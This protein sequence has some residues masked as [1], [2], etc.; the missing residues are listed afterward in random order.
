MSKQL[1][2]NNANA[3]PG[4]AAGVTSPAD[5]PDGRIAAFDPDNFAGG[6]LDLTLNQPDLEKIVFVQGGDSPIISP[7]F[8][9]E[10]IKPT[11]I[12]EQEYVAPVAQVTTVTPEAGTGFAYVRVVQVSEGYRPHER[13]T[14]EVKLDNKT[15][16]EIATELANKINNARP[17]FVS[18]AENAGTLVITGELETSFET[19]TD[20]EAEGWAI[21]ATTTPNFGTGTSAHVKAIEELAYGGNYTNRIYLPVTPDSYVVDGE[22]YDLFTIRVPTNTTPNI[23]SANKYL[24]IILAVQATATGINLPAV[25]NHEDDGA[26]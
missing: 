17:N 21:A 15:P 12:N 22:T 1:L 2:V 4:A 3:V 23:S 26:A 9:L 25:F 11:Q 16:A 6:T 7:V 19:Q 5:V 8:K 20:E 13:I 14:V 24:D 10:D 18:A